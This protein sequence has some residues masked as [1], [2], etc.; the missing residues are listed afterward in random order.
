MAWERGE[1]AVVR[2]KEGRVKK[3]RR[4][5]KRMRERERMREGGCEGEGQGEG[6]TKVV[7]W[8]RGKGVKKKE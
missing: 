7:T 6:E 4:K 1:T 8:A 2:G 3:K 5:T